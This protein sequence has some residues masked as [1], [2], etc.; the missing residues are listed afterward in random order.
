MSYS[1]S[2]T[3]M[4]IGACLQEGCQLCSKPHR[5]AYLGGGQLL[6]SAWAFTV[7]ARQV[8]A[9]HSVHRQSPSGPAEL[10][11]LTLCMGSHHRGLLSAAG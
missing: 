5:R 9:A 11:L 1:R 2:V 7:G 3:S 10:L 8:A 4:R 6:T